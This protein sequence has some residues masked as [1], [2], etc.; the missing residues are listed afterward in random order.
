LEHLLENG[1]RHLHQAITII[2]HT[3]EFLSAVFSLSRKAGR[4]ERRRR[5]G[6]KREFSIGQTPLFKK[7]NKNQFP[8]FGD[9]I[10]IIRL[11]KQQETRW[12]QRRRKIVMPTEKFLIRNTNDN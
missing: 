10:N 2:F 8:F 5:R 1:K 3:G 12:R 6:R 7:E 4:R 9:F 11:K